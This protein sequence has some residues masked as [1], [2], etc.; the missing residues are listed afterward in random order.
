MRSSSNRLA[1]PAPVA[2]ALR[3]CF[4]SALA[5]RW[6]RSRGTCFSANADCASLDRPRA[7]GFT[8]GAGADT[9]TDADGAAA[10]AAVVA[11]AP[12]T[13][14]MTNGEALGAQSGRPHH[15]RIPQPPRGHRASC[16]GLVA[17]GHTQVPP[18]L[19]L[20]QR[21]R[22]ATSQP[23]TRR[24]G[25]ATVQ[26]PAQVTSGPTSMVLCDEPGVA[27][28]RPP[29]TV[30]RRPPTRSHCV[31]HRRPHAPYARSMARLPRAAAK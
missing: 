6:M 4:S 18:H 8:C 15:M 3:T 13:R 2:F 14:D 19:R 5:A 10:A 23:I 9:A 12:T 27:V 21:A 1:P 22:P 24:A 20:L 31:A 7:F 11:S 17:A 29:P 16:D 28:M 26:V 30:R 25:A